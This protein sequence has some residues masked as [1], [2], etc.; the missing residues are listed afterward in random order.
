[1]S[2]LVTQMVNK[3]LLKGK[4]STAERIV[5]SALEQCR[6]KTGN[7]P[8]T[9][10]KR[11]VENVRPVLETK[12]RRVGGATYQVPIEVRQGRRAT[13]APRSLGHFSQRPPPPAPPPP[14]SPRKTPTRW[15]RPTGPS[16]I[17]GGDA[18]ESVGIVRGHHDDQGT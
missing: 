8:V 4:R 16:P 14:S 6:R 17:T 3:I 9:T 2:Q 10:L 7:D 13:L 5:Y 11:A 18:D 1:Q 15:P 12:S